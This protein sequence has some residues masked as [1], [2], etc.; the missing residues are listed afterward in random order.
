MEININK[1]EEDNDFGG[2]NEYLRLDIDPKL[3]KKMPIDYAKSLL[4]IL[5]E[6]TSTQLTSKDSN[7]PLNLV[8]KCSHKWVGVNQIATRCTKCGKL[9]LDI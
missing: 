2:F 7:L 8:S 6:A 1:W 9:E 5:T 4:K 3:L